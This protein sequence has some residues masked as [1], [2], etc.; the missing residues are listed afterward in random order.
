V[1][2]RA[3]SQSLIGENYI[4]IIIGVAVLIGLVVL[5]NAIGDFGFF[6]GIS[7]SEDVDESIIG[8]EMIGFNFTG[9]LVEYF[10][11]SWNSFGKNMITANGEVIGREIRED[12]V[13]FYYGERDPLENIPLELQ[14]IAVNVDMMAGSF[15]YLD[16]NG[17][18]KQLYGVV[19]FEVGNDKLY[20]DYN[21]ES[22]RDLDREGEIPT[23]ARYANYPKVI[24]WRDSILAKPGKIG[25]KFY[26]LEKINQRLVAD[27]AKPVSESS[28]CEL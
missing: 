6:G 27:F 1:A 4:G 20:L 23:L 12:F 22:Y 8:V 25:E 19:T 18:M 28:E 24:N 14:R 16:V 5:L 26:C 21:G 11:G 2:S 10:D 9:D 3:K 17:N 15:E 13:R 7:G